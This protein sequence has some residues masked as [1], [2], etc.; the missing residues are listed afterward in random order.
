MRIR[1][2]LSFVFSIIASGLFILFGVSVYYY[3]SLHR[4]RDFMN[5]L[6]ERVEITEKIFLEKETFTEEEFEKIRNRFLHT[7]PEET[8][9]VLEL[10]GNRKGEFKYEYPPELKERLL[11]EKELEFKWGNKRG[12]SRVFRVKGKDYL[13]I[14]TAVDETGQRYLTDLRKIILSLLLFGIPLI[15]ASSYFV[16]RQALMPISRKID[17]AN[18]ISASNL[19][20][21][22]EVLNSKDEIGQ[23]AIA[24]NQLLDRLENSFEAQK[25]F[26]RNASHEIRNPLTAILGEAE[27]ALSRKRSQSEYKE[28]LKAILREAEILNQTVS[29]LLQLSRVQSADEQIYMEPLDMRRFLCEVSD[30]YAFQNPEHRVKLEFDEREAPLR[31]KGNRGLLLSAF[32]NVIDNACKFSDNQTVEVRADARDDGVRVRIID[33]G[34]GILKEDLEKVSTPFFRG[35]NALG[36]NGSGIGLSLSVKII[37][38]HRGRLKIESEPGKGT[39]VELFL[40]SGKET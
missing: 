22:L 5:H 32:S 37:E 3:S 10:N 23:M 36:I 15:L 21:R 28:A 25:A 38:L 34:V 24:F 13:I 11:K 9:E 14:V 4:S 16:T 39:V 12:V 6:K 30:S 19:H 33:R 29:N 27:I 18:S 35:S 17:R 20:H 40:P 26:I 2:R 1:T 8:E 31:A 7:L